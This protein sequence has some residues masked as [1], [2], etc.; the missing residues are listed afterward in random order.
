MSDTSLNQSFSNKVTIVTGA[1]QGI[2]RSLALLL[3]QHGAIVAI[4]DNNEVALAK[5]AADIPNLDNDRVFKADVRNADQI[6]TIIEEVAQRYGRLD[7]LF[8]NAGIGIVGEARDTHLTDW[9]E[10]IDT[11]LMGVVHGML[12]AYRLMAEQGHGHIINMSSILGLIPGPS[13]APYATSKFGIY[14][15]STSLYH[16]ARELG[17]DI[18]VVCPGLVRSSIWNNLRAIRVNKDELLDKL[19]ARMLSC[20]KAAHYILRGVTA[21]RSVIKFP[22]HINFVIGLFHFAPKLFS[23]GSRHVFRK[24]RKLRTP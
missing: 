23:I 5:T 17:V 13:C 19:P 24:L 3:A 2:G 10:V 12:P 8:N 7:Y 4:I 9:R 18:S 16:E 21:R 15:L 6:E 1:A 22:F 20:D 14:G 11:N